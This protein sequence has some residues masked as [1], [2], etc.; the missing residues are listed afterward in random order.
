[1]G[2]NRLGYFHDFLLS[3]VAEFQWR[4]EAWE[5]FPNHYHFIAEAPPEGSDSLRPVLRK[6]HSIS[7]KWVNAGC[8]TKKFKERRNSLPGVALA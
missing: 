4:L 5:A 8:R 1:M 6:L 2:A 7:A 3:T